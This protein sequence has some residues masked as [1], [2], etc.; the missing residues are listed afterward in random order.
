MIDDRQREQSPPNPS[1]SADSGC[2][3]R[4]FVKLSIPLGGGGGIVFFSSIRFLSLFVDDLT[5]RLSTRP[6]SAK[7]QFTD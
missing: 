6:S 7:I 1:L 4:P 2:Y 3:F 5:P